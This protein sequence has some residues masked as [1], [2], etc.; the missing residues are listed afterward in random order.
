[1]GY[2]EKNKQTSKKKKINYNEGKKREYISKTETCQAMVN[3]AFN[4]SIQEAKASNC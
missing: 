3:Q 1:M 2:I 4:S